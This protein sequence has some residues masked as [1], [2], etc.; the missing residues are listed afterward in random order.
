MS[1][2]VEQFIFVIVEQFIFVIVEQFILQDA[3]GGN[4]SPAQ[5]YYYSGI[6][7]WCVL[8]WCF[9]LV[10]YSDGLLWYFTV[11]D[12]SGILLW[13]TILVDYYCVTVVYYSGEL[14]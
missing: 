6:L 13:W 14:L 12:Y 4:E 11:V 10:Y 9:T 8:F 1:L 5:V 2:I 7:L 3:G